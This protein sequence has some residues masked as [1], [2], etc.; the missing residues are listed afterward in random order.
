M[1]NVSILEKDILLAEYPPHALIG[2]SDV[3][4]EAEK[5]RNLTNSPH[6]L[7]VK[8]H[9]MATF[10]QDAQVFISSSEEAIITTAVAVLCDENSG[11]YEHGKM[12]IDIFLDT[13]ELK[14]PIKLFDNEND[15]FSWLRAQ[16]K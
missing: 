15:A 11:Y 7:L 5:R 4:E 16:R 12:L 10:S 9:G 3:K 14:F 2:L 8:L 6:L 13:K 1:I